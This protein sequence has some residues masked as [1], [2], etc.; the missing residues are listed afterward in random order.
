M[1]LV[2]ISG[3]NARPP[4]SPLG[5]M[6]NVGSTSDAKTKTYVI[7]FLG[8]LLKANTNWLVLKDIPNKHLK[9]ST[10]PSGRDIG[11]IF[12]F[13]LCFKLLDIIQIFMC[14]YIY[15]TKR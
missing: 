11:F 12:I 4:G 8:N 3:N 5:S 7:R 2:L 14:L 13:I 6:L 9:I 1:E 15:I 10:Q